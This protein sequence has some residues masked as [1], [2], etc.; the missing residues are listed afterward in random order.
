MNVCELTL[1]KLTLGQE[2]A[3]EDEEHKWCYDEFREVLVI[4][5]Q[6]TMAAE[7]YCRH[8]VYLFSYFVQNPYYIIKMWHWFLYY[9]SSY[10]WDLILAHIWDAPR[11]VLKFSC[12]I[13]LIYLDW[14]LVDVLLTLCLVLSFVVNFSF[15]LLKTESKCLQFTYL[16]H[17]ISLSIC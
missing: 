2:H 4:V 1:A 16:K 9:E 15:E 3:L 12:D 6:S 11:L 14:H 10:L 7:D 8:M 13:H 5:S 17:M